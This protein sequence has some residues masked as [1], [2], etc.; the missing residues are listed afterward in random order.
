M[1]V[2]GI[3]IPEHLASPVGARENPVNEIGTRRVELLLA[4]GFALVSEQAIGL[5]SE[6]FDNPIN[7]H[8]VDLNAGEVNNMSSSPLPRS[9]LLTSQSSVFNCSILL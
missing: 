3:E 5:A 7:S 6:E 2:D 1:F 8:E 9:P 4:Y